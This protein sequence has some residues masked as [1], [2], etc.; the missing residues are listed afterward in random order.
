MIGNLFTLVAPGGIGGDVIAAHCTGMP[1]PYSFMLVAV[2]L[3]FIA[4]VL[5]ISPAGIGVGQAAFAELFH[6]VSPA[7]AAAGASASVLLQAATVAVFLT[8]LAPYTMYRAQAVPLSG[9]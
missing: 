2:P 9:R 3:G 7:A 4:S 8:G 1:L 5:P 6:A